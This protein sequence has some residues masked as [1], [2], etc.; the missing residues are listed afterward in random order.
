ML[1]IRPQTL[2]LHRE[3][4]ATGD[5]LIECRVQICCEGKP[6]VDDANGS[7]EPRDGSPWALLST[8]RTLKF[9]YRH[10]QAGHFAFSGAGTI[11]LRVLARK[12][13]DLGAPWLL[14]VATLEASE[15]LREKG[16]SWNDLAVSAP[17]GD[18]SLNKSAGRNRAIG[19]LIVKASVPA[20]RVASEEIGAPTSVGGGA[21]MSVAAA[22]PL[23]QPPLGQVALR[24][25]STAV[26]G[27]T[28]SG[29]GG[30]TASLAAG[31]A[32]TRGGSGG[33]GGCSK[34]E[35]LRLETLA[36]EQ[37]AAHAQSQCER[38]EGQRDAAR[39]QLAAMRRECRETLASRRENTLALLRLRAVPLH[40]S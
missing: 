20:A 36:A 27:C 24:A 18:A 39:D 11:E 12:K 2:A 19:A 29:G 8:E 5:A 17:A 40:A 32:A 1:C 34:L 14:G 3:G 22:A 16:S 4:I 10:A 25:G 9:Q 30:G 35:R 13:G 15:A 28:Y 33:G 38:L 7:T 21:A 37:E 6:A 23:Q 31:S 26:S